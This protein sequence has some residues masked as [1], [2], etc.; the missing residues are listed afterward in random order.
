MLRAFEA[1]GDVVSRLEDDV[2]VVEGE[3]LIFSLQG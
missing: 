3:V 2:I 1:L